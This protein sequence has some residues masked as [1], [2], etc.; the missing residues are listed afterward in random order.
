MDR[1]TKNQ[2][3]KEKAQNEATSNENFQEAE[4]Y[5]E[6][7]NTFFGRSKEGEDPNVHKEKYMNAIDMYTKAIDL[8]SLQPNYYLNRANCYFILERYEDCIADCNAAIQLDLTYTGAY[9]RRMKAHEYMGDNKK[10]YS[11]CQQILTHLKDTKEISRIKHDM[12]RIGKRMRNEGDKYKEE[13]NRFLNDKNY[14]KAI[15]CF[16]NAISSFDNEAIYYHN[17]SLC[18]FHL[19]NY[20]NCFE[21]CNKAIETNVEYF[22]PYYQ[23]MRVHEIRGEYSEAIKDCEKFLE[24]VGNEKQRLTASK[25][26]ERLRRLLDRKLKPKSYNWSELRKN[27]IGISF[28]HKPPYLRSKV[29]SFLTSNCNKHSCINIDLFRNL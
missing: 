13:G 10:A 24:L 6:S 16:T 11:D 20:Q 17:R 4:Y 8:Y 23:R 14:E 22:R 15:E 3:E 28:V 1:F 26:L 21:D 2:Q 12:D 19:K 25:D 29:K 18:H 5:N 9:Y 7:G 27:A